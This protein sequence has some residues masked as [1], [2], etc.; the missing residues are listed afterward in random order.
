MARPWWVRISELAAGIS[1]ISL[2]NFAFDYLLYPAVIYW[3]GLV[4]G[5]LAMA[6][7]SFLACWLMLWFFWPLGLILAALLYFSFKPMKSGEPT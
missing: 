4:I 1:A 3:L 6:A 2:I 5:G 7:L